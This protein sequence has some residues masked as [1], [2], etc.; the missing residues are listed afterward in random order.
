ML[1]TSHC[2]YQDKVLG[3]LSNPSCLDTMVLL[4]VCTPGGQP[5]LRVCILLVLSLFLFVCVSSKP[6]L[7]AHSDPSSRQRRPSRCCPCGFAALG[8]EPMSSPLRIVVM[9]M[10]TCIMMKCVFVTFHPHFSEWCVCL[11]VLFYPHFLE[12]CVRLLLFILTS[13]L[14]SKRAKRDVELIPKC[15]HSNCRKARRSTIS[16]AGQMSAMA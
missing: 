3:S 2:Q 5:L 16:H 6:L 4:P 7:G 13:E 15:I 10:V 12:G 1:L 11:F 9:M 8:C 14:S